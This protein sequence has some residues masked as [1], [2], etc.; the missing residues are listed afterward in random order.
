MSLDID[1]LD[2]SYGAIRALRAVSL[3]VA[4]GEAVSLIGSNGAGKST[5]LKA[6]SGIANVEN[7]TIVHDGRAITSSPPHLIAAG[8]IA[9]VPEGRRLFPRMTVRENLLMGAIARRDREVEADMAEHLDLFPRVRERLDQDAGTLSG[10]EQQ[11]VA[12]VRGLMSRPRL[13]LLDEPSL[14]LSPLMTTAVFEA[15]D[16]IHRGGTSVLL[17]EQNAT[18]ALQITSRAYV[19]SAGQIAKSGPSDELCD[20]P[21]VREIYLGAIDDSSSEPIALP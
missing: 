3:F 11:M 6:I 20:D 18:K 14:G 9:H 2:V 17:V 21:M 16:R 1:N 4:D 19:L 8:G 5:L 12:I 15:I 7:G 13:L 10:G